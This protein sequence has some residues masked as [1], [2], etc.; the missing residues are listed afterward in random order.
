MTKA[1]YLEVTHLAAQIANADPGFEDLG[2]KHRRDLAVG[3]HELMQQMH[4]WGLTNHE[5][6]TTAMAAVG[7][8]SAY[9]PATI[10]Q[11]MIYA[12]GCAFYVGLGAC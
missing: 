6:L 1:D 7:W 2:N 11:G 10:E 3:I 9:K 5:G 12:F 8:T 4:H